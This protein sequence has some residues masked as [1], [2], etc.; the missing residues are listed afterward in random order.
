[1]SVTYDRTKYPNIVIDGSSLDSVSGRRPQPGPVRGS[2]R[3]DDYQKKVAGQL[4][5]IAR[6]VTGRA[7]LGEIA[8][9]RNLTLT[10]QPNPT[11]EVTS[12]ATSSQNPLAATPRGEVPL[13][14]VNRTQPIGTPLRKLGVGTGEGSSAFINFY[15]R[16]MAD[17]VLP[18]SPATCAAGLTRVGLEDD[19]ILLH[20]LVH[21][22]RRLHGRSLCRASGNG[23]ENQE[24]FFAIF[25]ANIYL[26]EKGKWLLVRLRARHNKCFEPL[27]F[28]TDNISWEFFNGKEGEEVKDSSGRTLRRDWS[29]AENLRLM[30]ALVREEPDLC[31]PL[32]NLACTFN[33]LREWL[34]ESLLRRRA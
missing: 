29:G 11:K 10:I 30:A 19:D 18:P 16:G 22:V 34:A 6:A 28:L 3:A 4:D 2:T 32:Y 17:S 13:A 5:R 23:Y 33:P 20:E 21:A 8:R 27:T 1:M 12:A 15:P 26:S 24:E 14:C 31:R 25:L 9:Y 7:V